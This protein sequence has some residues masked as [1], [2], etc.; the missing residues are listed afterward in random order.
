MI[1]VYNDRIEILSIGI[2]PLLQTIEGFYEGHSIPVNDKLSEIFLQLHISEKTVRGIP[3][4]VLKYGKVIALK[5][6]NIIITFPFNRINNVSDNVG[7]KTLNISAIKVLAEIR[8]NPNI[9]KHQ[10]MIKCDLGKTSIDNIIKKLKGINYI[11][12]IGA[13]KNGYWKVNK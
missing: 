5:D 4:I 9:T 1:I 3:T 6:N 12:R 11:E 10:L 8:N 2:I 13:N 7:D